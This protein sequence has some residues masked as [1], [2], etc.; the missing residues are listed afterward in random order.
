[1][2]ERVRTSVDVGVATIRMDNPPVNALGAALRSGLM[3]ALHQIL[4]AGLKFGLAGLV[5][6][7][8]PL[9]HGFEPAYRRL[10]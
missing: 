3:E 4:A 5:R 6:F 7:H 9:L 1:M 2:N 8:S 10:S